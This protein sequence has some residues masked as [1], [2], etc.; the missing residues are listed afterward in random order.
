MKKV[1]FLFFFISIIS[2]QKLAAQNCNCEQEMK[3]VSTTYEHDYAGMQDF[4]K[5]HP[6][7]TKQV[8][9]FNKKAIGITD[10]KACNELLAAFIKYLDNSHVFFGTTYAN[11]LNKEEKEEIKTN[12]TP[13]FKVL[14]HT[15]NYLKIPT[16][17][18]SFKDT[19]DVLLKLNH[20]NIIG[21]EHLILDLRGNGGGGDAMFTNIIP[22]LYTNPIVVYHSELWASENN[23]KMFEQLLSNE[24]LTAKDKESIAKI[25]AKARKKPGSFIPYH[26]KNTDTIYHQD[27][28]AS[29][30]RVS[31]LV[32]SLCMSATEGFLLKAKQ[33][34]KTSIFGYT[35]TAGG[36][37]YGDLNFVNSPSG[38]WYF[39]V[40]TS[41][42]SRLPKYSYDAT[43][44]KPDVMVKKKVKDLIAYVVEY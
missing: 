7:F 10:I 11:P 12:L 4:K 16:C 14:N 6:N 26:D 19:L 13:A 21:K 36:I 34:K 43:G 23:I 25:V 15:T 9:K 8:T 44:I 3:F 37:D 39:S 5:Q 24:F 38:L 17:D 41:R 29:P 40:P 22:Y 32:D 33:S 42:S 28:L 1:I 2:F 30:K 18:L 20:Q 27:I 31:I 35:A